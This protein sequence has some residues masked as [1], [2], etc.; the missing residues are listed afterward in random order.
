MKIQM[1]KAQYD[2]KKF[3][4]N[5]KVWV[6]MDMGN[7]IWIRFR[8]RGKGRYITMSMCKWASNWNGWHPVIGDNGLK[9][10][11]VPDE[12]GKRITNFNW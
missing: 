8:W 11:E 2:T 3:R 6:K 1:F 4:K 5:Q 7:Y 10:I 9:E 12:F